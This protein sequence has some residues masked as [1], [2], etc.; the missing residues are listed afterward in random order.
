M[1]IDLFD[2]IAKSF[3]LAPVSFYVKTPCLQYA[4]A[5]STVWIA[6]SSDTPQWLIRLCTQPKYVALTSGVMSSLWI[7]R[8]L[9]DGT[10][11]RF[12]LL[13]YPSSLMLIALLMLVYNAAYALG[14]WGAY[15][16]FELGSR[17]ARSNAQKD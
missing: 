1:Q 16:Y 3:S 9:W 14:F 13:L 5:F 10:Y 12:T 17:G 2:A 8:L 6:C 4:L 7:G 15:S 11:E